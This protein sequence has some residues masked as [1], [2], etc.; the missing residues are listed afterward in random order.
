MIITGFEKKGRKVLV[1]FDDGNSLLLNYEI[2][3]KNGLKM[4]SEISESR[5]AF[6]QDENLKYDIKQ[7][8][9]NLLS[10]R[11]HSSAEIRT[12]LRQKY[13][14]RDYIED[15]I[16]ALIEGRYLDDQKFAAEF[17]S[18][19]SRAKLWGSRKINAELKRRGIDNKTAGEEF[20]REH[21]LNP[22][23]HLLTA[24]EKKL[25]SLRGRGTPDQKL[26][27][28]LIAYLLGKGFD[29]DDIKRTADKIINYREE[30]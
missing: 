13:P 25:K 19:K 4:N 29:Y 5:F 30:D 28:K 26:R 17:V 2:F 10:R 21:I 18:E 6:L 1:H 24:A 7:T 15:I 11:L 14:N 12:K 20:I 3:M 16:N 22:G 23:E 8:A 27:Q 9:F